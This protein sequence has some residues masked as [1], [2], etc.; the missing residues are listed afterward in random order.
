ML[1]ASNAEHTIVEPLT[2]PP[3]AKPGDRVQAADRAGGEAKAP[4]TP[5]VVEKKKLWEAVQ[6]GLLTGLDRAVTWRGMRLTVSKGELTSDTL[7]GARVA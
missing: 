5:N 1:A 6:P 4:A 7:V 2:P 3:G